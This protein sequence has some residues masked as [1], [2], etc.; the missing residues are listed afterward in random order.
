MDAIRDACDTDNWEGLA[1][2]DII[3]GNIGFDARALG[4]ALVPIYST[5][6]PDSDAYLKATS[7]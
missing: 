7:Q 6:A 2:V 5:F 4:G 3:C 1:K